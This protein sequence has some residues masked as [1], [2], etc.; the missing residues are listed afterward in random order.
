MSES[1]SIIAHANCDDTYVVW[2]YPKAI[3]LSESCLL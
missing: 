3:L 2:R 1:I